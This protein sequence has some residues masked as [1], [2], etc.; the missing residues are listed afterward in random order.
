MTAASAGE[1]LLREVTGNRRLQ[2][3]IAV[4]ATLLLVWLWAVLGDWRQG[5]EQDRAQVEQRIERMQEMAGQDYWVERQV[6]AVALRD[7]LAAEIPPAESPGLAQ[8]AFQ[9]WLTRQFEGMGI[10]PQLAVEP[11]LA[12]ETLP[13]VFRTSATLSGSLSTRQTVELLRRIESDRQLIIIPA[14]QIRSEA[15]ETISLTIH[16][17]YRVVAPTAGGSR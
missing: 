1:R 12:L 17:Y 2:A 14:L 7:A 5:L 10:Q 16:A 6:E 3:G 9:S 8:A 4:I 11:P 13:G 15:N